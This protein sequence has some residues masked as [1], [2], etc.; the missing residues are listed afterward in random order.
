MRFFRLQA[1]GSCGKGKDMNDVTH[2]Y[3]RVGEYVDGPALFRAGRF[4]RLLSLSALAAGLMLAMP[5]C[6]A[7]EEDDAGDAAPAQTQKP[8]I[9]LS[10]A[11][12]KNAANTKALLLMVREHAEKDDF[13]GLKEALDELLKS[14]YP[15]L[16]EKY[17]EGDA[18]LTAVKGDAAQYA[19]ACS[20]VIDMALANAE[21]VDEEENAK[22]I[23]WMLRGK[24]RPCLSLL[25]AATKAKMPVGDLEV[26]LC[27]LRYAY[28][29]LGAKAS[30]GIKT[31]MDPAACVKKFYPKSRKEI[32]AKLDQLLETKPRGC[33]EEQQEAINRVNIVRFLCSQPPV[34]TY[35]KTFA[36]NALVAAKACKR[37]GHLSHDLGDFTADCNLNYESTKTM[38]MARTVICYVEDPGDNNR[39]VRGHRA[40]VLHPGLAKTGFGKIEDFQAMWVKSGQNEPRPSVG[41]G[42]PGRGYFPKEYMWGDGWS[43]YAPAGARL[44]EGTKVEMWQLP[45]TPR[46]APKGRALS[47]KNKIPIKATFVHSRDTIPTGQSVVFEPDYDKCLKCRGRVVGVYWIRIS[48]GSFEDEYVVELY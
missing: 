7:E 21:G 4:R 6:S 40:W 23:N 35:D 39:E 38:S 12:A 3:A 44:A 31:L 25:K 41:Y 13:T 42:Y 27:M 20:R 36:A 43:Y 10:P 30:S 5:L 46:T 1:K 29:K 15:K 16:E 2:R 14:A 24:G 19:L 33:D 26:R 34:V 9:D 17:P 28:D 37:A 22:F 8:E 48:S 47:D 18:P 32:L 45:A 11:G